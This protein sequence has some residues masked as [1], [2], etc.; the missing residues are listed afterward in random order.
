MNAILDSLHVFRR[1]LITVE[2]A[3]LVME[4]QEL[5]RRHGL[6][7]LPIVG[8][9]TLVGVIC[10]C[11]MLVCPGDVPVGEIMKAPVTLPIGASPERAAQVMKERE[12]GSVLLQEQDTLVGIVTR[13]DLV[14]K[15]PDGAS[16]EEV[17]SCECCGV[18]AHLRT[19]DVGRT[20]C[21]FCFGQRNEQ[22]AEA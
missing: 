19:D 8:A 7:H 18:Y 16:T 1:Q 6:H 17:A 2:P 5:A 14:G 9:E 12:V 10:T 3:T 20:F 11:D 13:G 22:K 21:V 4:A 15:S